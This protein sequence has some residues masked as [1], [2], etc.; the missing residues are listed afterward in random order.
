[1]KGV[2]G[3]DAVVAR[4]CGEGQDSSTTVFR[5]QRMADILGSRP[6]ICCGCET[7]AE[8]NPRGVKVLDEVHSK[9]EEAECWDVCSFL[10]I[11]V[12]DWVAHFQVGDLK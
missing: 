11:N 1:M 6:G 2:Y 10:A 3:G 8:V 4:G 7:S 5:L 9:S 12:Q